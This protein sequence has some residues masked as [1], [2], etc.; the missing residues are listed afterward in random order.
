VFPVRGGFGPGGPES[1]SWPR[2]TPPPRNMTE[3]MQEV[4]QQEAQQRQQPPQPPRRP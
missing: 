4:L 3:R 2:C 1:M